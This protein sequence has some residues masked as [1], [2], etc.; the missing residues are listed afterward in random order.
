MPHVRSRDNS[1]QLSAFERDWL[2]GISEFGM[3]GLQSNNVV[4]VLVFFKELQMVKNAS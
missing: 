3:S 4:E 2:K 1:N